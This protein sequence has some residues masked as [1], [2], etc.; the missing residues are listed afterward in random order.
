MT[1]NT[2]RISTSTLNPA[3]HKEV[4]RLI[5]I[6]QHLTY[7][8][9]RH[10]ASGKGCGLTLDADICDIVT[11]G[12]IVNLA[13]GDITEMVRSMKENRVVAMLH[14]LDTITKLLKSCDMGMDLPYKLLFN[15][16]P[17]LLYLYN[18]ERAVGFLIEH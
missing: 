10:D 1:T 2:T 6:E 17:S 9:M 13:P 15:L 18:S 4:V 7:H 16:Q 5:T 8:L 14:R 12:G 11:S 3:I